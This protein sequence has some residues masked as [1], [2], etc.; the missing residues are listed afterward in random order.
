MP[1]RPGRLEGYTLL[2]GSARK[3]RTPSGEIISRYRYDSIRL[4]K[5]GWKNR[6]QLEQARKSREWPSAVKLLRSARD[7]PMPI[8]AF[9]IATDPQAFNAYQVQRR[10]ARLKADVLGNRHDADDPVLTDPDGPLAQL[11]VAMGRR[12]ASDRW[13]VGDTPKGIR[14]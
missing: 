6:Y 1:N 4:Q 3:Y 5:A 14:R 12:D 10:R 8:S 9:D 2:P 11:L 13:A 7:E